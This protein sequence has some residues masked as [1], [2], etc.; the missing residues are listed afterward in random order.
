MKRTITCM[1]MTVVLI[2]SLSV[3]AGAQIMT[4]A[5]VYIPLWSADENWDAPGDFTVDTDNQTQGKGCVS[6]N[7]NGKI[8]TVEASVTLPVTD[9]IGLGALGFDI[10][11]SDLE[12]F[13]QLVDTT[14]GGIELYSDFSQGRLESNK[15]VY[16]WSTLLSGMQNSGCLVEGWNNVIIHMK[17]ATWYG[18][19]YAGG[20]DRLRIYWADVSDCGQDLILKFDHFVLTDQKHSLEHHAPDEWQH[21]EEKHWRSCK[22]CG[23]VIDEY[24]HY[25]DYTGWGFPTCGVSGECDVCGQ[26][27]GPLEHKTRLIVDY[28]ATCTRGAIVHYECMRCHGERTQTVE[29]GEPMEHDPLSGYP[30]VCAEGHAMKCHDCKEQVGNTIPHTFSEWRVVREATETEDG[31]RHRECDQC[32][33]TEDE[34]IPKTGPLTSGN[35]LGKIGCTGV[36]G[37]VPLLTVIGLAA[38]AMK[39]KK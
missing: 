8:G 29:Q 12:A 5:T 20:V 15:I 28:E 36:I 13:N 37:G 3:S 31:L 10:Y 38:L 16:E 25:K 24:W 21:D 32:V 35:E 26:Q 9:A 11:I 33:Y 4:Y 14:S 19:F 17:N 7:L 23:Q 18:D 27:F 2:L 34:V 39:K 22:V 30:I 1:L 6:I